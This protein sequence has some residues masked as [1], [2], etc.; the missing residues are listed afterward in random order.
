M[1]VL[2]GLQL[3]LHRNVALITATKVFTSAGSVPLLHSAELSSSAA[4]QAAELSGSAHQ[5]SDSAPISAAQLPSAANVGCCVAGQEAGG[6]GTGPH[7]AVDDGLQHSP[8]AHDKA[9]GAA[10]GGGLTQV[11]LEVRGTCAFTG[12]WLQDAWLAQQGSQL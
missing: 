10:T 6:R 3:L 4:C 11:G 9:G 1:E 7:A 5:A 8:D 12:S 2:A